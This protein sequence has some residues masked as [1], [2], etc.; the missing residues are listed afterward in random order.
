MTAPVSE[1]AAFEEITLPNGSRR[2]YEDMVSIKFGENVVYVH[3]TT[4]DFRD[5]EQKLS[6]LRCEVAAV[7][8]AISEATDAA[9]KHEEFSRASRTWLQ[10]DVTL[11]IPYP[12]T[13]V[14]SATVCWSVV[15]LPRRTLTIDFRLADCSHTARDYDTIVIDD[16]GALEASNNWWSVTEF[17]RALLSAVTHAQMRYRTSDASPSKSVLAFPSP[18]S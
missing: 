4:D 16:S 7:L 13:M 1:K 11:G 18:I 17:V 5:F 3:Q 9:A 10:G 15:C 14:S 8:C 12:D 6:V 2:V